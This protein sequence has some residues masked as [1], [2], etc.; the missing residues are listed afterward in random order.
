MSICLFVKMPVHLTVTGAF[1]DPSHESS[2]RAQ[3]FRRLAFPA[4]VMLLAA[5]VLTLSTSIVLLTSNTASGMHA[6]CMA[7]VVVGCVLV[8]VVGSV[9]H[10]AESE[11]EKRRLA[12]EHAEEKLRLEE[13]NEQLQVSNERLL[14]DVQHRG[15]D[16]EE[17]RS[18][19][20]RGLQ[21][22]LSQPHPHP[23][24]DASSSEAGGPAPSDS[25]P[26]SL[27]PGPPSSSG[28]SFRCS[29]RAP[30]EEAEVTS[31][32]P[33][34]HPPLRQQRVTAPIPSAAAEASSGQKRVSLGQVLVDE[35]LA[36]MEASAE[37][38]ASAAV[39]TSPRTPHTLRASQ[40]CAH[41][42]HPVLHRSSSRRRLRV[43]LRRRCS[44]LSPTRPTKKQLSLSR[45]RR[46]APCSRSL[47]R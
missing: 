45:S 28:G 15:C 20:R 19:I 44:K 38:E 29:C 21:A 24:G 35:A 33:S 26:P 42:Q 16:H 36:E 31:C 34:W 13:R 2:F 18:T 14:Y 17:D 4:H 43:R 3:L 1:T 46:R 25:P 11:Q 39:C 32:L 37:E 7:L 12:E 5:L 8:L 10:Y 30:D 41:T 47:T 23:T 9:S 6:L 40:L 27:P 22:G